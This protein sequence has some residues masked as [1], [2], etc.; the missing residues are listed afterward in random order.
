M[1][2]EME[3]TARV[4]F[5]DYRQHEM[6][7]NLRIYTRGQRWDM[8]IKARGEARKR[9]PVEITTDY[10]KQLNGRLRNAMGKVMHHAA[11]GG[12]VAAEEL[13]KADLSELAQAGHSVFMEIFGQREAWKTM[14]RHLA[15]AQQISIEVDSED[16]FIPWELLYSESPSE[17]LSYEN[18]WGMRYIIHHL[19][20][21]EDRPGDVED[22]TI[23]YASRPKLGL[24]AFDDESLPGIKK[25]EI[26]FFDKLK[27]EGKITLQKLPPLDP[28]VN[29]KEAELV[30][31]K[32]FLNN[33]L[34][35]IHFAC[36]ALYDENDQVNSFI[37]L[38][39]GIRISLN[40]LAQKPKASMRDFPLV[41]LNACKTG[42]VNPMDVRYFAGDFIKYGALG[43]VATQAAV[44]D[45]LAAD[46]TR[47]LYRHLLKGRYLGESVLRARQE[48]LRQRNPVG[49]WYA[50][51]ATPIIKLQLGE[52]S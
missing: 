5:T 23:H 9:I 35:V 31:F 21:Q 14:Q 46:F 7:V 49:L 8:D 40:D 25:K 18:F 33:S 43:V 36:H 47:H 51:Y 13:N 3:R 19:I 44:P 34:H 48:L 50:L 41:V 37:Q 24:F 45:G 22:K 29:K 17:P 32:Q 30:R 16:F 6:E 28:R 10:L 27:K 26:P 42:Q 4:R 15:A 2:G 38:S 39:D 11:L 52:G 1:K 20:I 12:D